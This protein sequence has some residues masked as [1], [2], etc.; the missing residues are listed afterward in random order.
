[1]PSMSKF[2]IVDKLANGGSK[3][4]AYVVTADDKKSAV[5][6]FRKQVHP[7]LSKEE[8]KE[9]RGDMFFIFEI[10]DLVVAKIKGF[11]KTVDEPIIDEE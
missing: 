1:M 11:S 7:E 2:L 8:L 4:N 5:T 10:P 3:T 9:I 6:T